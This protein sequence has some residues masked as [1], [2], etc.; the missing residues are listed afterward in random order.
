MKCHLAFFNLTIKKNF[1]TQSLGA[2]K[3]VST[4]RQFPHLS[5]RG[6]EQ[7]F[8]FIALP[9]FGKVLCLVIALVMVG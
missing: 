7:S 8:V 1:I 2:F 6:Y 4:C 5:L 9:S 3:H